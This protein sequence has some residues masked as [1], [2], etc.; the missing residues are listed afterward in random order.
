MKGWIRRGYNT[1]IS[2]VRS[3]LK[4]RNSELAVICGLPLV[5]LADAESGT[6]VD[7]EY[8]EAM[9]LGSEVVKL[10]EEEGVPSWL[11]DD[12]EE[13]KKVLRSHGW[14]IAY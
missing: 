7:V 12:L 11:K 13:I 5:K 4:E 1:L 6:Y 14:E 8:N 3:A 10:A 9:D 2:C